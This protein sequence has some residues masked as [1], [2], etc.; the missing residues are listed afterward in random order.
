SRL[1]VNLYDAVAGRVGYEGLILDRAGHP[2]PPD[3]VLFQRAG[4]PVRCAETDP[5]F[6]H[7]LLALD[8]RLPESDMLKAVH[9][10]AADFYASGALGDCR[11]DLKSLDETALI[12]LGILLEEA[13]AQSLEQT[14]DL[15]FVE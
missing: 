12:A 10:Y 11:F 15:A 5:Y 8:Q 7:H 4:A 2:L 14:G 3:Q 6:A 1:R 9:A 13:A